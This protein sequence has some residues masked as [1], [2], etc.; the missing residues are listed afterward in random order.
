ML[1]RMAGGEPAAYVGAVR[2]RACPSVRRHRIGSDHRLLFRL[3]P[4][5]IQVLD[6]IPRGDLERKV[7]VLATQYD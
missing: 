2:L 7:K 1:A 5:R 6:L 4:D 3:L